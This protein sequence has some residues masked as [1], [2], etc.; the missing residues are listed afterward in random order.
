MMIAQAVNQA[1]VTVTNAFKPIVAASEQRAAAAQALAAQ[2]HTAQ[3]QAHLVELGQQQA[4]AAAA[5]A[6]QAL[7][8]HPGPLHP[9][10]TVLQN[11][12]ID[13]ALDNTRLRG[14]A[15]RMGPREASI[16][17]TLQGK[18]MTED[19]I[20][21]IVDIMSASQQVPPPAH[22]AA[23]TQCA[24]PAWVL[25]EDSSRQVPG[26][27]GGP[28]SDLYASLQEGFL[29]GP[30]E[31]SMMGLLTK[32]FMPSKAEKKVTAPPS[33]KEW[34][35]QLRDRG[36][37]TRLLFSTNPAQY[38][39]LEWLRQSVEYLNFEHGWPVASFYYE[40]VVYE[41]KKNWIVVADY[42]ESE[43]FKRGHI[44]AAIVSRISEAA[45]KAKGRTRPATTATGA[46][47]GSGYVQKGSTVR[48]NPTDTWC[49][50][51]K[52]WYPKDE[53]HVWDALTKTGSCNVA[54]SQGGGWRGK[55]KK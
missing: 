31:E 46:A 33:Y 32:T 47:A 2:L 54:K 8:V 5:A 10:G 21:R 25:G 55:K 30:E 7:P 37:S 48:K 35:L 20:L 51:H 26:A 28:P 29:L 53:D 17:R 41:W 40:H 39:A 11:R 13:E 18:G 15:Q 19:E 45:Y 3:Q 22:S 52:R 23:R 9:E 42:T 50:H 43:E 4:A 44:E 27:P 14:G 36:W 1:T 6:R 12:S 24:P 16:R 49:D 34:V 38:W